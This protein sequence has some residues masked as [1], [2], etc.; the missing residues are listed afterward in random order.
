MKNGILLFIGVFSAVALSWAILILTGFQTYGN[1][2]PYVDDITGDAFPTPMTGLAERGRAV[3][4]ELG[5]VSCHTQQVRRPGFGVD[6]QRG[7][8]DRQSVARDY[9]GQHQVY[10]GDIR[11]G[12]DLRN[13]GERDVPEFD[14]ATWHHLHLYNPRMLVPGS[15]MPSFPYLYEKR[16]I[17]GQPSSRALPL[18]VGDGYEVVPTERAE[19]LLA[20]LRNQ[21]LD[22]S[23][24]EAEDLTVEAWERRHEQ[25][26]E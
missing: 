14:W 9:I 21:R 16:K 20:Y 1:L 23:L 3:Y 6:H 5:C 8:G 7:W 18:N 24:P 17:V 2:R 4:A 15:L 22:Y 25:E 19:A 12:P 11:I 13:V 10:I 26:P